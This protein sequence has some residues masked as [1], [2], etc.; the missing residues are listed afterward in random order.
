MRKAWSGLVKNIGASGL[1]MYCQTVGQEPGNG[2]FTD[3]SSSE[4]EGALLLAGE[5][6]YKRVTGTV[7]VNGKPIQMPKNAA[8][9]ECAVFA[10]VNGRFVVP[11]G[12]GKCEVY[13]ISGRKVWFGETVSFKDE[14][15]S[16]MP[17]S[18]LGKGVYLIK[19]IR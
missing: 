6:L 13:S 2:M 1:L 10:N 12:A 9:P 5:E 4:G 15:I 11:K 16:G 19:Y 14:K 7:P 17:R 8:R 3:Y 18:V